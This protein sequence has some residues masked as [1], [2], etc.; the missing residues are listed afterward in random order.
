MRYLIFLALPA[1]ITLA[2]EP[3]PKSPLSGLPSKP[4][5]HIENI[6]AL[7]DNA[8]LELGIP[9]AD[10][11]WG[12]ACGRAWTAVMPLVPELRGAFLF[13]EGAHGHAKPDGHYQDDLWF[14]DINGHRWVCCYPGAN[15]K[16]LDLKINADG[17][18]ATKDGNPIPVASQGHGYMMNA[19]DTDRKCFYSMPNPGGFWQKRLERRLQWLKNVPK[20]DP[21][22]GASPWMF[23]SATG[24]WNRFRTSTPAPVSGHGDTLLYAPTKKQLFFLHGGSKE[25]WFYDTQANR[26]KKASPQGPKPPF[27]PEPTSCYDSKR[28]RI[29]IGGGSFPSV[30]NNGNAFWVYDLKT[31]QWI[32]PKPAGKPCK[33]SNHYGV[34]NALMA[35]DSVNDK[36]L[37]LLYSAHS[38][39]DEFI[40][41][42]V[43]DPETNVWAADPLVVP[44]KLGRNRQMKNGF[45]D[46]ALN[47]VFVH[48]AGDSGDN[49]TIW[50][51]RYKNVKK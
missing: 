33:G 16:T 50:V 13:G 29:Y 9:T 20:E 24:K 15:T 42:Y 18:E 3:A 45:Y 2:A 49:G 17:F 39:K 22:N 28:D 25:V 14:Y 11:K 36:V 6:K 37:L 43:Y 30:P 40:G 26:W 35:Y 27:G 7:G 51:Y 1:T 32:D 41:V 46:P 21:T 8:W 19:Y 23:D 5:P 38:S 31:D 48:S 4:G 44:E 47:A 34:L 10:P 12:T